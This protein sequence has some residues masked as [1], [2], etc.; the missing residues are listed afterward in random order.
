MDRAATDNKRILCRIVYI[1]GSKEQP[2]YKLRCLYGLLKGLH[3]TSALAAVSTAIQKSQRS[4]ISIN[5][6]GNEITLAHAASQA[7]TSNKVGVSCNCKGCGTRRCRCYKND[8][9]C[10]IY[11]HNTDYDC[12]NL[13]SLAERTEIF[14]MPRESWGVLDCSEG[15]ASEGDQSTGETQ[16]PVLVVVQ[17]KQI[18]TRRQRKELGRTGN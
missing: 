12:K 10:S 3:P 2:G 17:N 13:K 5:K 1:A 8:L 7:S 14:L 16:A 11:C 4:S 18:R 15:D 9:K 6:T